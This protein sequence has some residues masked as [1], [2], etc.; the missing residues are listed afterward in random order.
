MTTVA[1]IRKGMPPTEVGYPEQRFQVYTERHWDQIPHLSMLPEELRFH[2]RVVANVLP[3]RVN[4]YVLDNLIDWDNVPN[5][6]LFQLT[7]PQPAMLEL[8]AFER[9][10]GL[11]KRGA[12]PLELQQT[13]HQIRQGLNPHP[14]DQQ[15]MNVPK[16]DGEALQG[17]QHKYRET[18]LFFPSQ[19]QTCHSYCTFCFRW[20]QFIGDKSLK[21]ASSEAGALHQYLLEH[22]QVSD[23]LMTG[24]DPMVMKTRRLYDYLAPLLE[25]KYGH[26]QTIRIGTKSLTFWPQRFV[27]DNDADELLR[28]FERLV[29]AGKHVALM[30]HYNHWRELE[31][32]IARQ[33]I[34]RIQ[35]TGVI[36]RSQGP[37][38]ANI[39]DNADVWARLWRTQVKLGM[40]P[41]YMFV[42]R[43]TGARRYF[44]VP[45]D[46]AWQI[47]RDA[48]QQVS[49]LGRT[50]RGPSMSAGPGKVEVQ[51]VTEIAGEKVFVLRFIQARDPDWVQRPFFAK[52]D[53]T[54]TWFDQLKP[55][56]A[57]QFF[58]EPAYHQ[59]QQRAGM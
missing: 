52:Y 18:V 40:V 42:E 15:V 50:A 56:F 26:V 38:L 41:Y 24:G 5:D 22:P 47:Y 7:F 8:D 32:P 30:A 58:F 46:Q 14:A 29:K 57:D 1:P 3:F 10:A 37:L 45:L 31:T 23:L 39:N 59:L 21:F 16:V 43:D 4:R 27:S 12:S 55:A 44:E 20:A 53:P 19:G 36:I 28:L 6:P 11:L 51:G 35:A 25:P 13:I 34:A 2:M 48:S 49:G 54:A 9:V 33:A 17:L